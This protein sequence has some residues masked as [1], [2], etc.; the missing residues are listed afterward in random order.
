MKKMKKNNIFMLFLLLVLI[1]CIGILFKLNTTEALIQ[2]RLKKE[3]GYYMIKIGDN[4]A[5][6]DNDDNKISIKNYDKNNKKQQWN[7]NYNS[8]NYYK[9]KN[10]STNRILGLNND[11]YLIT[12][13]ENSLPTNNSYKWD[14]IINSNDIN[15]QITSARLVTSDTTNG[16][17]E[18]ENNNN[19]RL[20]KDF[21]NN[22]P[23]YK[24][25]W[26]SN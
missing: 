21:T 11:G 5:I 22:I 2:G 9:I 17:K 4:D 13:N 25:L 19:R 10:I 15:E 14:I 16:L 24:F 8:D 1:V 7:I 18:V 26:F 23:I 20:M 12:Y 3:N 6:T